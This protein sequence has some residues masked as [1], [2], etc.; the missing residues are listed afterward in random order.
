MPKF[1]D[2]SKQVLKD[3]DPK[4]QD[5]FDKVIEYYD[6]KPLTSFRGEAEQNEAFASGMSQL[7]WPNSKHNTKPSKAVD[8]VPYFMQKAHIRW[9][10]KMAFYHFAGFVKGMAAAMGVKLRWGGDWNNDQNLH[11]QTLYDLPHF[12]LDE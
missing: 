11:D 7:K 5:V 10:D 12:E 1:S 2:E 8:V 6:C 9:E 4:L 3:A